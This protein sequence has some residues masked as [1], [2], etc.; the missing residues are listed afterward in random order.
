MNKNPSQ[1]P[2]PP[3]RSSPWYMLISRT[4]LFIAFQALVAFLYLITGNNEAW[5][6]SA[7]W[8]PFTVILTNIVCIYLLKFLFRREGKNFNDLF[9]FERQYLKPDIKVVFGFLL[10]AGPVVMLPNI[11]LAQGLFGDQTTASSMMFQHLPTL[12]AGIAILIF[13]FSQGLAE[14]P[15]YFGYIMPRLKRTTHNTLMAIALPSIMLGIQH[16]GVPLLFDWQFVIYRLFMFLPFAF[17]LG[18]L[19]YWRPRLLP[20]MAIVHVVMNLSTAVLFFGS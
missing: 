17:M 15:T 6:S 14:L 7:A 2:E 9:R 11:L 13:P 19:L 20:Y 18:I 16:I 12:A 5:E 1:K 3:S 4:I 10:V 8:W